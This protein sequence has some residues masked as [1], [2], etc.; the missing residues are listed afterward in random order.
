MARITEGSGYQD[1]HE[2]SKL[3]W[4]RWADWKG[5]SMLGELLGVHGI[6]KFQ[7]MEE[8]ATSSRVVVQHQLP[9]FSG[10]ET[11]PRFIW[12]PTPPT[13]NRGASYHS[14]WRGN[15]DN[16]EEAG[17]SRNHQGKSLKGTVQS[18]ELCW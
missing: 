13:S 7:E 12:V 14:Q 1:E 15:V 6:W 10:N 3:S 4:D 11:F 5:E 18:Q 17:S 8:M 2:Q 16:A 9:Y